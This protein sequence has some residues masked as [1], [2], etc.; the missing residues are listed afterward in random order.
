M[1]R[2]IIGK[3]LDKAKDDKFQ[4][5]SKK[6]SHAR[7]IEVTID[8]MAKGAKIIGE[9]SSTETLN[10][11]FDKPTDIRYLAD[12]DETPTSKSLYI[13]N[14][15]SLAIIENHN[16]GEILYPPIPGTNVFEA[17]ESDIRLALGLSE[18]GIDI[19][20]L[21]DGR[22]LFLKIKHDQL[23]RSHT[24]ILG[25]TGSG[26]SYLAAKIAVELLKMKRY[27][28]VPSQIASP[29]I[30][31]SSG[32][33]S[34]KYEDISQNKIAA[35]FNILNTREFYFPLLNEKYLPILY[36]IYEFDERQESDLKYWFNPD[37]EGMISKKDFVQTDLIK[38]STA[39]DIIA[40]FHKLK[41][42]STYQLANALE[43]H[44]KE[45]NRH[46]D[47]DADK[48]NIPYNI[49][50]RMRKLNLK[51]RKTVPENDIIEYLSKGLIIDLSDHDSYE[52]R[53]IAILIFL[54]Q[55]YNYAKAG[56]LKNKILIFIDEVHNYIPSVYKSFCKDEILRI[57]REGRKYGLMLCL[58]SQRPRRVD[59]T[60]LSQCGNTFI[61]KIQNADDKK[62]IFDS[63]SL[64][65]K[66][67]NAS[68][69]RF[70]MGES[71]VCGDI[72]S[73]PMVCSITEIDK[74][75]L[76]EERKRSAAKHLSEMKAS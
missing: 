17:D 74:S 10:P 42:T 30:F 63:V 35:V 22:G 52:E 54:R 60:A 66:L 67:L 11:Y 43:E 56:K 12:D 55:I 28:Q 27:S 70:N 37:L 4:I 19:G 15:E 65:D 59:P 29:V 39:M 31:D 61:F 73:S 33:Y 32:E 64:P 46:K 36:E 18:S 40:K 50:S 72:V 47:K 68:I 20:Y 75:F 34:G 13:S 26:K 53:Q 51:I 8:Q 6:Y 76:E 58:L 71:M 23:L 14:V 49:L 69:A 48:I 2:E 21:K 38:Q 57:A 16:R 1:T 7:F 24:A 62:H 9:I 41:I 25:Q 5:V 3:V 45:H 44:L